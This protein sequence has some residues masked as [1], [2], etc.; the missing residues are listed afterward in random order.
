MASGGGTA[1][2][3]V[4]DGRKRKAAAGVVEAPLAKREPRRGMGV[5]ELERIRMEIE[6]AETCGYAIVPSS[7]LSS[8]AAAMHHFPPPPPS[9]CFV[10]H[11]PTVAMARHHQYVGNGAV[12]VEYFT[13]YYRA[14]QHYPND[15]LTRFVTSN[16]P[17]SP[18]QKNQVDQIQSAI[19]AAYPALGNAA[20]TSSESSSSAY[21]LQHR[22]QAQ[23]PQ[24]SHA[25]KVAFVDL[26]DSDDDSAVEELDLELKL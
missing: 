17:V 25:R 16:G 9:P 26:V 22:H 19:T 11:V 3:A 15:S 5:A 14:H 13:P 8:P 7:Y 4:A 21:Q 10:G 20:S 24:L 2:E 18:H 12:Q 23:P 1:E 6:M